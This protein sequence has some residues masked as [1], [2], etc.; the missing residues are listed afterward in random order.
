MPSLRSACSGIAI[1]PNPGVVVCCVA[2]VTFEDKVTGL[3][4]GQQVD[5][6]TGAVH[7]LYSAGHGNV[8][9]QLGERLDEDDIERLQDCDP[10]AA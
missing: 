5:I 6:A 7:R 3:R 1:A 9:T 2:T 8:E 10:M 4:V